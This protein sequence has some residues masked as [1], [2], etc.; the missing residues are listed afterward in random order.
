MHTSKKG[1]S[2][3]HEHDLGKACIVISGPTLV[4]LIPMAAAPAL[5]TMAGQ[6]AGSFGGNGELFAQL[7]MTVPALMLILTAPLAGLLAE[8]VGRRLVLLVALVL[9]TLAGAAALVTIA[10]PGII[11][12]GTRMKKQVE[13]ISTSHQGMGTRWVVIRIGTKEARAMM[14]NTRSLPW[15]SAS[16]PISREEKKLASPPHR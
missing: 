16:L 6:F 12:P 7:V 3:G 14:R 10:I 11:L 4:V 15:R 2:P 13:L 5:P 1:P 9:F 8:R